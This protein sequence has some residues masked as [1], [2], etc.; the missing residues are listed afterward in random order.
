[1]ALDLNLSFLLL[2]AIGLG[3]AST[4]FFGQ[5]ASQCIHDLRNKNRATF[6]VAE[7]YFT[8]VCCLTIEGCMVAM[9]ALLVVMALSS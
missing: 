7:S 8:L 3:S 1:M 2:A 6:G 4:Y 9:A 5:I